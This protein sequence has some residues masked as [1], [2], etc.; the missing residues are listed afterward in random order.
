LLQH[1]IYEGQLKVAEHD[2]YFS[3]GET[4]GTAEAKFPDCGLRWQYTA[5]A[6]YLPAWPEVTAD[7]NAP[8]TTVSTWWSKW[9]VFDGEAFSNE[10]RTSFLKFLDLPART[11]VSLELALF[12]SDTEKERR[13]RQTLVEKGWRLQDPEQVSGT[14]NDYRRYIQQS[15]GEFSCAKP[16]C[17]RLSNAWVSD[18]TLCYLASGKPAIVQH[19]GLSRFLPDASGLFRFRNPDEAIQSLKRVEADYDRHARNAR[20]LAEEFFDAEKVVASILERTV[21]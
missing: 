2:A 16:S 10:K 15:R 6:V 4:V 11:P 5:P 19:T 3:I 7:T 8:Y 17:L 9:E 14:P 13:D 20:A 21:P 18:R 12:M 1:W